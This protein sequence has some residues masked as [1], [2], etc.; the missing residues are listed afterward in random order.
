[1]GE[2]DDVLKTLTVTH[3]KRKGINM[4]KFDRTN[5]KL[6]HRFGK[7][8]KIKPISDKCL[9]CKGKTYLHHYLC[10][11]CWKKEQEAKRQRGII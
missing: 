4:G 2:F 7:S 1:M 5:K 8:R 6:T 9:H 3:R 11:N 10:E